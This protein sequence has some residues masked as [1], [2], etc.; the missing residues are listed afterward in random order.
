METE[1]VSYSLER[2]TL[3]AAYKLDA[4]LSSRVRN[5]KKP[6]NERKRLLEI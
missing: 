5:D 3:E 2:N 1:T 4:V 6:R